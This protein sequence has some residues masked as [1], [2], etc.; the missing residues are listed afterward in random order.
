MNF[1]SNGSYHLPDGVERD[2]P[3]LT[4]RYRK[5]AGQKTCEMYISCVARDRPFALAME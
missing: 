5:T 2:L 3:I 4:C 1:V